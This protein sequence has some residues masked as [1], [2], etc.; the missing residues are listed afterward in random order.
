[1]FSISSFSLLAFELVWQYS[2]DPRPSPAWL[3]TKRRICNAG[4]VK[5]QAT[6]EVRFCSRKWCTHAFSLT[7]RRTSFTYM[8]L[9][10][11]SAQTRACAT[12]EWRWV[13]QPSP[14]ALMHIQEIPVL[15]EWPERD[16]VKLHLRNSLPGFCTGKGN[17]VL[18]DRS[19]WRFQQW[20]EWREIQWRFKSRILFEVS[21]TA[22]V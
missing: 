22:A 11:P 15:M 13:L 14:L 4:E 18:K 8:S 2:D 21:G 10:L 7:Y 12:K 16:T 20:A 6:F 9:R 3:Q 5:K 17:E 1:M 19:S